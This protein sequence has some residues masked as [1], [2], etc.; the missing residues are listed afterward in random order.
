MVIFL[1]V[2][3]QCLFALGPH[4]RDYIH[5]EG[6]E[7]KLP[8]TLKKMRCEEIRTERAFSVDQLDYSY[9][10]LVS[11][12]HPQLWFQVFRGLTLS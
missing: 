9:R 5:I 7:G 4:I 12:G 6:K 11:R 8:R 3:K 2:A 10:L 1:S